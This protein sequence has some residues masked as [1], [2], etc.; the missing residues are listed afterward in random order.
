MFA[1]RLQ[2]PG[3]A[4]RFV[5]LVVIAVAACGVKTISLIDFASMA[6]HR[7]YLMC[8]VLD[9]TTLSIHPDI[10]RALKFKFSLG[11]QA[12]WIDSRSIFKETDYPPFLWFSFRT[13]ALPQQFFAS[14]SKSA[15][16][17]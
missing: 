16:L 1:C 17:L 10:G 8:I 3:E 5:P 15:E 12:Y 6:L 14:T 13:E 2:E 9:K 11:F 7:S 4:T